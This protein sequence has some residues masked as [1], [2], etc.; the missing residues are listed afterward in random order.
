MYLQKVTSRKNC[1]KKLVFAG[2]LKVNAEN[3][4][5][6][7]QDPDPDP[8]QVCGSTS[9]SADPDPA[10]HFKRIR[11]PDPAAVKSDEYRTFDH[12]SKD[13]PELHFELPTLH[14]ELHGPIRLHFEPIKLILTQ[15]V[16]GSSFFL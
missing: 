11:N 10:F 1:V 6:R 2:I 14:F 8:Y 16:S 12:W 15:S 4:R 13:L 5:I 9:L 3:S 7:I